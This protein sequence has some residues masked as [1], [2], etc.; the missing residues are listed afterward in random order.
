[1]QMTSKAA[2]LILA[3][4]AAS[5]LLVAPRVQAKTVVT[6]SRGNNSFATAVSNP[7][8][9][10]SQEILAVRQLGPGG[11]TTSVNFYYTDPNGCFFAGHATVPNDTFQVNPKS[12]LLD[13]DF[14]Q[15]P[16]GTLEIFFGSC[17]S[18][19]APT[20][21]IS[22]SWT[23]IGDSTRTSGTNS[24]SF[25]G[26]SFRFSGTSLEAPANISGTIFGTPLDDPQHISSIN[27]LHE[28][29][30]FIEQN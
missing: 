25:D 10:P 16:P 13:V 27:L 1:M 6:I 8:N 14:S 20:G 30:I 29:G 4:V 28:V 11:P 21:A 3:G 5:V 24:N 9:G 19:P 7:P 26:F 22:V 23:A 17:E 2:N 18:E 12:A 15:L